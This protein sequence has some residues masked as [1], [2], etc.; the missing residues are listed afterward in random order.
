MI[1][2]RSGS[3][4]S[5]FMQALVPMVDLFAVLAIVFM[6]HSNDEIVTAQAEVQE[7]RNALGAVDELEQARR[8]RREMMADQATRTLDEIKAEREREAQELLEQFTELMAAQQSSAAAEYEEILA[9]IEREHE[10]ELQREVVSLEQRTQAELE[11]ARATL[12]TNFEIQRLELVAQQEQR[13]AEAEEEFDRAILA[14]ESRLENTRDALADAEQARV[15]ALARQASLDEQRQLEVARAEQDLKEQA[16]REAANLRRET[17][18][19]LARADQEQVDALARQAAALDEQR[20]RAEQ[21]LQERAAREAANS[22]RETDLALARAEQ[23]RVDALARQAAALDEQRQLEVAR[24]EQALQAQAERDA[25]NLRR[26]AELALARADLERQSDLAAQRTALEEE[27]ARAL[28]DAADELAPYLQAAEAKNQIIAELNEHFK[29]FDSS[30]VEIDPETGKVKLHFQESYFA[31]GSHELSGE[32]KSFLRAMIPRY[33][34]SIYGNRDAAEQ[35]ES[36]NI[37][38]MAS[39][40]YQGVY[41]DINDR[42]PETQLARE[43]NMGLSNRRAEALYAFIFN[44]EEMGDYEFRSRLEADMSIAALGFQNATPVQAELVGKPARCIEYDC[45][46]E[47]A[48]VLQF[49]VLS[50]GL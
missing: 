45:Q 11:D 28:A 3:N 15:D 29:D 31:L 41:I 35:I 37:S 6:I 23:E 21:E 20:Q 4:Q 2:N 33:A 8:E 10:E 16:E 44:A 30:V 13:I 22:R 34:A 40:I 50:G 43:Y 48:T 47:Q 12:E 14:T 32:M 49:Q 36:L 7:V 24:A 25:A 5:E 26:E 19:A 17:E 18:L 1:S 9:Q 46:Q 38:G 39:P 42:S 27:R